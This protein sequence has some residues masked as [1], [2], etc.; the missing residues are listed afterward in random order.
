MVLH[1]GVLVHVLACLGSFRGGL[2]GRSLSFWRRGLSLC[3]DALC[4]ESA[5][6]CDLHKIL[7]C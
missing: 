7:Y 6:V 1:I 3:V 5:H 2:R 4:V